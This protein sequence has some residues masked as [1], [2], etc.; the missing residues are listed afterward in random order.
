MTDTRHDDLNMYLWDRSVPVDADAVQIEQALGS[1]AFT[2]T[3]Q[4]ADVFRTTSTRRHRLATGLLLAASL[5]ITAGVGAHFWRLSWPAGQPWTVTLGATSSLAVGSTLETHA[6]EE[7]T[8]SIARIGTM[9]V[10]PG[11][12]LSLAAT[13]S[14]RHLIDLS[15]GALDVRVWAPPGRFVVRTPA[16]D[17]VDLGCV[18]Q[19]EVDGGRAIVRVQSGWVRLDNAHGEVMIPAGTTSIMTADRR[20][21]V[22][23]Y[24][25]ASAAFIAAVRQMETATSATDRS[26]AVA[27]ILQE[28]RTRDVFT[29]LMLAVRSSGDERAALAARAAKLSPPPAGVSAANVAAGDNDALWKWADSL[30]L[31]P[32]KAWWLNWKDVFP[33]RWSR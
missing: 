32:V 4:Q 2:P 26:A 6:S 12:S 8:V 33:R 20:A 17:V 15:H 5:L 28:A 11:S 24:D 27:T 3:Q 18:F 7:A 16:G 19:L 13:T 30:P 29:L 23:V 21:L 25:D 10:R 9:N 22:P 1:L 31:P 14:S